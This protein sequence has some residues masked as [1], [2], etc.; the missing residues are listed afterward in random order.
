MS[1]S[2]S[3]EIVIGL[4]VHAQ[5]MTRTK[6][7]CFVPNTFGAPENTLVGPVSG[8]LPGALPVLNEQAVKL[9]VRAGLALNCAINKVSIFSRKNYFYP[10][11]PKGYQISQF[12][13][14]LCG[15][16]SVE[17][18][19][20]GKAKKIGIERIH[21]EEDA[22]K[23][24]HLAATTLVNLNRS[25]TPLIEIVSRPDMRSGADAVAYL[26]KL[27]A[28]LV[29]AEIC[30]GNLEEGNFRC[31]VNLSVRPLGHEK[32]GTRTELKN[33]NSFRFIEKAIEFES[34]RQIAV[35]A[36]GG[37]VIQETR[38]WDSAGGKTFSQRTKEEAHDYR[39]FPEPDLPPLIVSDEFVAEVKEA[40]PE[41]PE[42]KK[43]RFVQDYNLSVYDADQLTASRDLADYFE[44][45]VKVGGAPK[46]SANWILS[47]LL[48]ELKLLENSEI[49][50]SPITPVQIAE[51]VGLIEK[52]TI[53]GKIAKTVFEEMFKTQK[54]PGLIVKEKGLV[55]V[56]DEG[57]IQSWIEKTVAENPSIVAEYRQG[58]EKVFGFLVGQVMKHSGG[59]A[60]PGIV[61]ERLKKALKG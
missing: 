31:D 37:K 47:E 9:A 10:D 60:N 17:V 35:V 12:D 29:F 8:G 33:L 41:L 25:G 18:L 50:Q 49:T 32:L 52:N 13:K 11:L 59:K 56:L 24:L 23:S 26:K 2:N 42:Q 61:G 34:A 21:M 3:F 1:A 39:Y 4:E 57:A 54:S 15:E 30:D 53:S 51:L 36:S 40:M 27:H 16:G 48:R 6:A 22:G 44:Q 14:P 43:A 7:F 46:L 55:Q 19:V 45:T 38:G 5:L 20:D 28:I 58:K